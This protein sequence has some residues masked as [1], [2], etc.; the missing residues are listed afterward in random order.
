VLVYLFA[1]INAGSDTIASTLRAIFYYLFKTPE[2]LEK[3]LDELRDAQRTGK[4]SAPLPTWPQCQALPYLNAVIKEALRLNPAL[5]LPMER[6]VPPPGLQ[7]GDVFLPPG[8]I[9]GINPW[10]LH[11]DQRIF[12]PDA[13]HWQPGRWL[14]GDAEKVKYMDHHLLSF[15]A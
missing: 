12:G 1:N 15:G 14:S 5:A 6:I 3:L 13:E 10:V 8:T 4:L 9:V 7:I 11:R 2:S